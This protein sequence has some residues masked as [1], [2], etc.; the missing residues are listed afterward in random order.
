MTKL[1]LLLLG[2]LNESEYI[3][4]TDVKLYHVEAS[5]GSVNKCKLTTLR[6]SHFLLIAR[7]YGFDLLLF[8]KETVR[9]ET[10]RIVKFSIVY[11]K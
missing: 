3:C 9:A 7:R 10:Q 5:E 11:K 1:I 8:E 2:K 6:N 4:K